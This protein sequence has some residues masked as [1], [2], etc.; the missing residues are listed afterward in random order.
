M[1][2]CGHVYNKSKGIWVQ[3]LSVVLLFKNL[4]ENF[5][6][7]A[8]ACLQGTIYTYI[9]PEFMKS[10]KGPGSPFCCLVQWQQDHNS[11][12]KLHKKLQDR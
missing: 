7:V 10:E 9:S 12:T 2:V 6:H 11:R 8:F 3:N 5:P 1:S 4:Y